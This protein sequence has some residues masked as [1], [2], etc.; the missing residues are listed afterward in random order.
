ML[1]VIVMEGLKGRSRDC[2]D[3][4]EFSELREHARVDM[5]IPDRTLFRQADIFRQ[6]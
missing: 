4:L 5:E 1:K 3:S 6:L 2:S